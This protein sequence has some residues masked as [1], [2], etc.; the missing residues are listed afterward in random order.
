LAV[1]A[2]ADLRSRRPLASTE[3]L[4]RFETDVLAGLV[5][6]RSAAGRGP[7]V[8]GQLCPVCVLVNQ[9]HTPSASVLPPDLLPVGPPS[10]V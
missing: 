8:A 6:A 3:E 9:L 2:V 1:T 5:L 10:L 4:E 7:S